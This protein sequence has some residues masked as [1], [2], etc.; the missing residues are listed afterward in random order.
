MTQETN[1]PL[2][3]REAEALAGY[4]AGELSQFQVQ[5]LLGFDNRRDTEEWLGRNGATMQYSLAD[6][7]Q[8]RISLDRLF[9]PVKP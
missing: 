1:H 9:G 5:Q 2:T 6:L 7:E 4:Q 8:D 3:E